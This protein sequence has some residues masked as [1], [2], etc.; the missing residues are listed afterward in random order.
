[1]SL[2][3]YGSTVVWWHMIGT[4]SAI[5]KQGKAVLGI[6]IIIIVVITVTY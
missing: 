3:D 6:I 5:Y 4:L 2:T 1:M